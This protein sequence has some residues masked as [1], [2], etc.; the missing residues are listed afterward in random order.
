MRTE[1]VTQNIDV[2]QEEL[3]GNSVELRLVFPCTQHMVR[4]VLYRI[5]SGLGAMRLSEDDS[6]TI[7]I[8][9]AEVLN[10]V[11]EHAYRDEGIGQVELALKQT[12]N[13][14]TCQV[15]DCGDAMPHFTIPPGNSPDP[16]C[17]LTQQAEGGFGWF[18]IRHLTSHLTYRRHGRRN[19]L[20]FTIEVDVPIRT[21]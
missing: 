4:T 20:S 16:D 1:T 18:L 7:E 2:V 13:G 19:V 9:L 6:S 21:N 14:I 5:M 8:V 12:D 3:T 15:I 11:A 10:N 17:P